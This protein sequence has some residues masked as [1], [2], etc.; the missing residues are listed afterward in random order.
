[1]GVYL[2]IFAVVE[3]FSNN[4]GGLRWMRLEMLAEMTEERMVR[5]A[6]TMAKIA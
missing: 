6:R 1:M 5:G 4:D 2:G 3:V